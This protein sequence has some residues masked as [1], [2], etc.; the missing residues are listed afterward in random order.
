MGVD[1]DRVQPESPSPIADSYKPAKFWR[2]CYSSKEGT[3]NSDTRKFNYYRN[4]TQTNVAY[5]KKYPQVA[6]KKTIFLF[7]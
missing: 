3:R 5:T 6:K 4:M 2:A 7:L 1:Q